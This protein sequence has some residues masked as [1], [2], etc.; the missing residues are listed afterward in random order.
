MSVNI[1][2]ICN[3]NFQSAMSSCCG[4]LDSI[5][6][7]IK[8]SLSD[9]GYE[10]TPIYGG[11]GYSVPITSSNDE[12]IICDTLTNILAAHDISVNYVHLIFDITRGNTSIGIVQRRI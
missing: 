7:D 10:C 2:G 6:N 5:M 8:D 12:D 11:Y 1:D 3:A 9:K 4:N